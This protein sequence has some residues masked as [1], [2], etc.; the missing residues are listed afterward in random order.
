[1]ALQFSVSIE[2]FWR[3][4]GRHESATVVVRLPSTHSR[5][6]E[7]IV[8][9]E[10]TPTGPG[11]PRL[12]VVYLLRPDGEVAHRRAVLKERLRMIGVRT[13]PRRSSGGDPHAC[14]AVDVT[15]QLDGLAKR[16]LWVFV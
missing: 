14:H 3:G 2:R 11:G 15:Q 8:E 7:R 5:P 4:R 10:R 12:S 1:M 6:P 13:R 9:D 16:D